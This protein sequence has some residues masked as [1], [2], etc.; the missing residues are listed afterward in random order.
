MVGP[1]DSLWVDNLIADVLAGITVALTLIPQ[2]KC[3]PFYPLSIYLC[4]IAPLVVSHVTLSTLIFLALSYAALANLNPVQGL[5]A[6]ILP[7]A[8]YT[9]LGSSMQVTIT[10]SLH[11]TALRWPSLIQS[12]NTFS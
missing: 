1:Y 9:F 11:S 8:C 2:G 5:Y 10:S 4:T 12:I 3:E 6:A 7:S